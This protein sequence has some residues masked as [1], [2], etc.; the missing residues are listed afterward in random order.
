MTCCAERLKRFLSLEMFIAKHEFLSSYDMSTIKFTVMHF[1]WYL[2]PG[3][4]VNRNSERLL[5]SGRR[6][7]RFYDAVSQDVNLVYV[8]LLRISEEQSMAASI[9]SQ[10]LQF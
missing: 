4:V 1:I 2:V 7:F 10:S 9:E 5:Q 6:Q 8:A 3:D